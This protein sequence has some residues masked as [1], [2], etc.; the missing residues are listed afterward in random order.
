MI[1]SPSS[2]REQGYPND[3]VMSL[4][5]KADDCAEMFGESSEALY[6]YYSIDGECWI[7]CDNF[8]RGEYDAIR[9]Y[10]NGKF[11]V[12]DVEMLKEFFYVKEFND[13]KI[14]SYEAAYQHAKSFF[15]VSSTRHLAG[16]KVEN[17]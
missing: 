12:W 17:D 10:D 6:V 11:T 7:I 16:N 5:E 14:T 4:V 1:I 13:N 2:L 15:N 3:T 9:C 8:D